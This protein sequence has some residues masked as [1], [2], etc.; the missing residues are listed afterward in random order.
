MGRH[1]YEDD[2]PGVGTKIKRFFFL[3]LLVVGIAVA[4]IIAVNLNRLS[5]GALTF[6]AGSATGCVGALVPVLMILLS[7]R[8]VVRYL[9]EREYRRTMRNQQQQGYGQ[10]PMV[11]MMPQYP[12][13]PPQQQW[14]PRFDAQI[15]AG[16]RQYTEIGGE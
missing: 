9:E 13:F 4:G 8:F 6:A 3:A 7:L 1:Y 5:E 11:I 12:Q 14:D 2:E 15:V 16:P 10:Q